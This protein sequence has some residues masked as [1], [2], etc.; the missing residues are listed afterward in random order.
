V[1]S[2]GAIGAIETPAEAATVAAATRRRSG[3]VLVLGLAAALVAGAATWSW[4][5]AAPEADA[6]GGR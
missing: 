4:T 5:R 3:A 1:P 2:V 6:I